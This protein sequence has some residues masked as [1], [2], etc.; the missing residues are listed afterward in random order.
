[1]IGMHEMQ[2]AK[3]TQGRT[4]GTHQFCLNADDDESEESE[5]GLLYTVTRLQ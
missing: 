3:G 2:G 1:M 5:A 4:K